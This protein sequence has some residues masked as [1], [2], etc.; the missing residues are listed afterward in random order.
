LIDAYCGAGFFAR[1]LRDR[2]QTV[3]GLEWDKR[4]VAAARIE[5]AAHEGYRCGDVAELLGDELARF[6][7][8]DTTLILDPP[9]EGL[10]PGVRAV[11]QVQPPAEIVY[12]SCNPATLARDLGAWRDLYTIVSVTPLDMFPQTAEIEAVAHLQKK[13]KS[14]RQNARGDEA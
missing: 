11:V 4:A 12:V 13:A 6:D 5:A 3:V 10:A 2:Y 7:A 8:A 9:A 1:A 14:G